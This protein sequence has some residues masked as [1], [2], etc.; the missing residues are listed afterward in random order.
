MIRA[1]SLSAA[2]KKDLK[3]C[4]PQ[5]VRKFMGWVGSVQA[6]GLEE[7]RKS[8]GWHDEALKGDWSGYRSIRLNLAYRAIYRITRD[9][10]V[11]LALVEAV[12]K[13]R[14]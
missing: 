14:Y 8:S 5:V 11:E 12:N 6:V 7:V 1:V 9:G 10:T 3:T 4:P 13:H 2:A